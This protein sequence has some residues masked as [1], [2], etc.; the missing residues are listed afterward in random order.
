MLEITDGSQYAQCIGRLEDKRERPLEAIKQILIHRNTAAPDIASL[1]DFHS[2]DPPYGY[3]F[4][5]FPY[6][7][8]VDYVE[9]NSD[10]LGGDGPIVIYQIHP[11]T[12]VSP[13]AAEENRKSVGIA[14]NVDGRRYPPSGRMLD[15][16]AYLCAAI[17]RECPDGDNII[18]REHS[19]SKQCPGKFVPLTYVQDLAAMRAGQ[20]KKGKI[21]ATE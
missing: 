4:S 20:V 13:H 6:H 2:K 15:A 10:G 18:I 5:I 1:R 12:T 7:F 9:P 14:L 21:K 8:F 19:S 16:V 3:P 17:R 11:L